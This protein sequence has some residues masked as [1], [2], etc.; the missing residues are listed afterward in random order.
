MYFRVCWTCY[1]T[2]QLYFHLENI[3]N[4]IF[5]YHITCFE[6]V[7]YTLQSMHLINLLQSKRMTSI[8]EHLPV[9][10]HGFQKSCFFFKIGYGN[11]HIDNIALR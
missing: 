3:S 1:D 4:A 8:A 10:N 7:Q 2:A 5:I 6:D 11:A 9:P